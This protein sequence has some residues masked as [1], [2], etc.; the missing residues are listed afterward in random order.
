MADRFAAQSPGSAGDYGERRL[1][2]YRGVSFQL[3]L[4]PVFASWKLTPLINSHLSID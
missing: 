2:S 4:K 1:K 3:A